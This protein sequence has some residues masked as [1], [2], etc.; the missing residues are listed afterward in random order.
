MKNN[1]I[2]S[3]YSYLLDVLVILRTRRNQIHQNKQA[4]VTACASQVRQPIY[5]SSIAKW[6]SF[7]EQLAPIKKQFEQAGISSD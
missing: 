6:R 5:R 7:E 3:G 1:K 4:A 2:Y